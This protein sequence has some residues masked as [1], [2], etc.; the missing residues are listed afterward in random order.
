[1]L[2]TTQAEGSLDDSPSC[3]GLQ[4]VTQHAVTN[5]L[6][7]FL[8]NSGWM[9]LWL[10]W[11]IPR[12]RETETEGGQ[13]ERT[14]LVLLVAG[15]S[16]RPPQHSCKQAARD[17]EQLQ[18]SCQPHQSATNDEINPDMIWLFVNKIDLTWWTT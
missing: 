16:A 5:V 2:Y 18:S 4:H 10:A 3:L 15:F 12:K 17:G 6:N 1:M 14:T 9:P 8:I 11:N 7:H 13:D